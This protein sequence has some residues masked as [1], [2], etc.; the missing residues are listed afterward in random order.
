MNTDNTTNTTV[1]NTVTKKAGRHPLP[2]VYP[3]G[4]FTIQDLIKLNP[5]LHS[6][7]IRNHVAKDLKENVISLWNQKNVSGKRGKPAFNY[8]KTEEF[9]HAVSLMPNSVEGVVVPPDP[10]II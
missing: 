7:T 5:N 1:E 3:S 10:V 6:L 2:V 4:L 8:I 9:D